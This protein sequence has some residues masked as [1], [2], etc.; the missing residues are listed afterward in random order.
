MDVALTRRLIKEF[1]PKNA[2][3]LDPMAGVGTTAVE[4]I[5][6]GRNVVAVDIEKKFTRLTKKNVEN[7]KK[8][9]KQSRFQLPLGK[10]VII[11]GDSRNLKQLLQEHADSIITSPPFA[12]ANRGGGIAQEGC[13]GKHGKDEKLH[14]RHDRP[15]SDNPGNISNLPFLEGVDSVLTSPPFGERHA[16]KDPQKSQKDDPTASMHNRIHKTLSQNPENIGNLPHASKNDKVDVVLTSPPFSEAEHNYDHGLKDLGR[17]FRGREAWQNKQ[18]VLLSEGNVGKLKHGNIDQA[19]EKGV[20][21]VITSPPYSNIHQCPANSAPM[22]E[23]FMQQLKEKGF[24]EWQSKRYTEAEWRAMNHGRIDGRST[25]GVKKDA[26]YSD[27]P[28]NIGNLPHGEVDVVITSPPYAASLEGGTKHHR[29]N[30]SPYKIAVEKKIG[31]HYSDDKQNIGNL[32]HGKVDVV[33]TS[34]PYAEILGSGHRSKLGDQ[35]AQGSSYQVFG[36]EKHKNN[37]GNLPRGKIDTII[38]SPPYGDSSIQD[39]GGSNRALLE[40]ENQVR[41]SFRTKG[42]FEHNGKRYTE[43]EWRK[44]N[45]GELKPRGIPDLWTKILREGEQKRYNDQN[46]SNIGNLEHVGVDAVLTSPPFGQS[47]SKHAG[48]DKVRQRFEGF[49][50]NSQIE[51]R[52]YS[53]DERNIGNLGQHGSV[54]VVI[55]SPPYSEGIGHSIGANAGKTIPEAIRQT[56]S[57]KSKVALGSKHELI[58]HASQGNIGSIS[59]HGNIKKVVGERKKQQRKE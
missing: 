39:Y 54:D 2:T 14:L 37:I 53:E 33:I 58:Q 24:I 38:T 55:T 16:Y 57:F 27:D 51:A 19:S 44:I 49:M 40:F 31:S 20:D 36:E 8:R 25:K 4:G 23:F 13:A 34:P 46:Q 50:G 30:G 6:L 3:I 18:H 21:A 22:T 48:G 45:K 12:E 29:A 43:E 26:T 59:D 32:Q 1:V 7:V 11:T 56:R 17:N 9:N 10:A 5:L 42:Y 41:E 52:K 15:L 35:K 28:E 47:V